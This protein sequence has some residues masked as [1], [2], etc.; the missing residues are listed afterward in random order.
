MEER[1]SKRSKRHKYQTCCTKVQ[2][3]WLSL[4]LIMKLVVVVV[5]VIVNSQLIC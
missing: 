5:V 1:R 4:L 3:M 2:V